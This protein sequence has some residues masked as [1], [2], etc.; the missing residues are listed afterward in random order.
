MRIQSRIKPEQTLH[1][2]IRKSDIT[3]MRSNHI[4]D[5]EYLQLAT[6]RL[7]AGT[8][9][10]PHYHLYID[11]PKQFRIAQESW[12]VIQGNVEV[13]Y[14]DL[15]NKEIHKDVLTQGDCSVTLYGGHNYRAMDEA[16]VYEFKTGPYEGV[17][18]DKAQ[19]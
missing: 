9:F 3:E 10:K 1:L 15:D 17:E 7:P 2:I 12:V 4:D 16:I 13:T 5:N 8:T 14:Y 6:M 11:T 18:S 19:I